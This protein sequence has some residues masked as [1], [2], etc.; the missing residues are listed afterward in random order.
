MTRGLASGNKPALVSE[1]DAAG[2]VLADRDTVRQAGELRSVKVESLR[3]VAALAVL[4]GHTYG[5][6]HAY[7]PVVYQSFLHRI[8]LGGGF[9]VYLFFGLSGYLLYL[10]FARRDVAA[11]PKIDHRRYAINRAVRILPLYYAVVTVCLIVLEHGS[12]F[13]TWLRF[14]TFSEN[15]SRATV[16]K[17]DGPIWSLVVELHFYILLPFLAFAIAK[18]ARRSTWRAAAILVVI[19]VFSLFVREVKVLPAGYIDPL[20]R[21]NIPANFFFFIPGM[22]LALLRVSWE[23]SR[24]AWLK[25]PLRSSGLWLVA[26]L[27]VWLLVFDHYNW[28][29]LVGVASFLLIG[30]CVL[31][32]D[33]SLPV[34]VLDWRPLAVIGTASYSLYLWHLPIVDHLTQHQLNGDSLPIDLLVLVPLTVAVALVSYRVIEAPFLRLRRRWQGAAPA[35]VAG[36]PVGGVSGVAR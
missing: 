32:L 16:G 7:G 12:D 34:R 29:P 10:P 4:V 1:A 35:P 5:D 22:L 20:W 24:P 21:Y 2:A 28:D 9:A 19:G 11:G 3:A 31:P 14:F 30:S 15:F 25:G 23:R 36:G 26:S 13:G 17:I 27:P 8:V 6:I 33:P 18:L